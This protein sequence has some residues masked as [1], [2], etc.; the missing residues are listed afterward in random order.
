MRW[1]NDSYMK[2]TLYINTKLD[3]QS[4]AI[5]PTIRKAQTK[6][7]LVDIGYLLKLS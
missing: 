1:F 6:S 7:E 2:E 3:V 4:K 5:P